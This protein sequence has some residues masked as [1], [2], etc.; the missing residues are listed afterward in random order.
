MTEDVKFQTKYELFDEGAGSIKAGGAAPDPTIIDGLPRVW[1]NTAKEG[2]VID[3]QGVICS[4]TREGLESSVGT[5]KDGKILDNHKTPRSGF[6]IYDDK[7]ESPFL[8]FLLDEQT[9]KSLKDSGGGSIDAIATKV[10]DKKILKMAGVGYSIL[11]TGITPSCTKEAGCGIPIAGVTPLADVGTEWDFD[12]ADYTIDQLEVACAWQN[13]TKPKDERTKEDY[14]LAYKTADGK[15]VLGGVEAAMT[16]LNEAPQD[17]NIP[18]KDRKSIYNILAAGYKLF[19]REPPELKSAI[20]AEAGLKKNGGIAM[21]EKEE[22]KEE[23]TFTS[24]QVADLKAAAVAEATETLV[25][26]QKVAATDMETAHTAALK[27]LGETHTAEMETQK[28]EVQRQTALVD[29]LA[30]MYALSDEAKKGLT[31]AKSVEDVFTLFSTLKVEKAEPVIAAKGGKG[32]E[33]GGIV[34]G[35]VVE[36]KAPEVLKT[37]EVGTYDPYTRK[38]VPSFREEVIG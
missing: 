17:V 7:F 30:T 27:A 14:E 35:A 36:G 20:A 32:T 29:Q 38:Y 19:D 37:E 21:G 34:M 23:V 13:V 15:I 22:E 3:V 4:M 28:I 8:A 33:G 18:S 9:V 6:K 5:W 2:Q 26:A 31:E 24:T 25:N 11:E 10:Q 12:K 1:V 16:A